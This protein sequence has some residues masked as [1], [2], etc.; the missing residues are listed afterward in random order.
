MTGPQPVCLNIRMFSDGNPPYKDI[1][2]SELEGKKVCLRRYDDNTDI[3]TGR[4]AGVEQGAIRIETE[5]GTVSIEGGVSI[6]ITKK[7]NRPQ[8]TI[9][10]YTLEVLS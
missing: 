2:I 6:N 8:L 1:P 3:Y 10:S 5:E 7:S 9:N 4:F